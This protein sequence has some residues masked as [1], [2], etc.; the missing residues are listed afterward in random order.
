MCL[1]ELKYINF[2]AKFQNL[3]CPIV[4]IWRNIAL[5]SVPFDKNWSNFSSKL[6]MNIYLKGSDSFFFHLRL[7]ILRRHPQNIFKKNWDEQAIF[8]QNWFKLATVGLWSNENQSKCNFRFLFL[9]T[10]KNNWSSS[11]NHLHRD[12]VDKSLTYQNDRALNPFLS[13]SSCR[14]II[15]LW[16][17]W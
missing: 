4:N 8:G 11:E 1:W 12:V 14:R 6:K 15:Y 9:F 3:E 5:K 13:S 7:K 2:S 16:N 10:Y 17:Y